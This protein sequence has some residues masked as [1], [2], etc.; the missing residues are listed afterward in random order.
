M[1][2]R[3]TAFLIVI[4]LFT[5]SPN[6]LLGNG[7][8][9]NLILQNQTDVSSRFEMIPVTYTPVLQ[10]GN[11]KKGF[12]FPTSWG[13]GL[14][15]FVYSQQYTT[16]QLYLQNDKIKAHSDSLEQDIVAGEYQMLFKPEIQI[17]PFLNIYG[18]VGYTQGNVTPD[19]TAKNIIVE[20]PFQDTTYEITI[21]TSVVVNEPMKYNGPVYG[22]GLTASY[23][24]NNI[25]VEFD[26][27][28]S[29]VYPKDMDGNLVSNRLSPKA[30]YLINTKNVK[31]NGAVWLG[32][33]WLNNTQTLTGVV[34][35]REFAGDL[36]NIIGETADY[37]AML[38]AVNKWN[39][40]VGGSWRFNNH[41]NVALEAGFIGRKKISLGFLYSF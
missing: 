4:C 22:F 25:F 38:T 5:L 35:V 21:D 9:G 20:I 12:H 39:M 1:N 18:L 17:L 34:D 40:V 33:S 29:V 7:G 19:I 23:V 3:F 15:G 30:G 24:Y 31:S 14:E 6:L 36:A 37:T 10:Q 27:N 13:A 2:L 16:K 11:L 28:Y 41:F 26:Y 32:A 8:N